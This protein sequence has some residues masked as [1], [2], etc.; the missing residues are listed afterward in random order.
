[1]K[2]QNGDRRFR[3]RGICSVGLVLAMLAST[4]VLGAPAQCVPGSCDDNDPCTDDTCDPNAGCIHTPTNCD[5]GSV[6]TVDSCSPGG[7]TG[8][9]TLLISHDISQ[10]ERQYQKNGTFVQTWGAI[11]QATG[12]AVD[13]SGVVYICN[14]NFGN[15]VIEKR[16]PGNVSLGTITA[17]V[18][19]QWIEDMGNF[20]SGYILAGTDAGNVFRIDTTTGAGVLLFSTGHSIIGV[21]YDGANIWTTG[22][23]SSTLVYKRDLS[24]SVL[25]SFNTGQL[26]SGIGYDPDD[27]TLW[28]GHAGGQ[29][30][31]H[32]QLGALLGGFATA[33]GGQLIDGLELGHLPFPEG[34]L[35][36]AFDCNDNDPCTDDPCDPV[37][38][39]SHPP[40][41]CNDGNL[42]TD[43]MCVPETGCVTTP[44]NAAC[45]DGNLCTTGDTCS[46]GFCQP[47]TPFVCDDGNACTTDSCDPRTGCAYVPNA[48]PCSDGNACTIEDACVEG[49]CHPG[50]PVACNDNNVCTTDSCIPAVGCVYSNNT[51]ACND[52]NAC[53]SGEVCVNGTCQLGVGVTC[54]PSDQC[55]AAGLCDPATGVC[56]NPA[57]PNGTPCNDGNPCTVG[58]VCIGGACGGV[59]VITTPAETQNLA[60]VNRSTYSWSAASDATA[61]DAVRGNVAALPVG[62]SAG[63]EVCFESLSGPEL[64]D[65][66]TP[67]PGAGFWYLSRA[68]NPCGPGPY[69]TQSNGTVRVTTSCP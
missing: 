29:V 65:T 48:N 34:C 67:A 46:G 56:S 1:M 40:H 63:G 15:N 35:H 17:T 3:F 21:T 19:G 16:G 11:G 69:G 43:D 60:A 57:K 25:A 2:L 6:C 44:N 26:N 54:S 58:E 41:I 38:G 13:G 49:A 37:A 36:T 4:Y 50:F 18:A 64:V 30:T 66:A 23:S 32:S 22:G 51:G 10:L 27:G 42:C 31:H 20:T 8:I 24:G 33:A 53:T 68:R 62:S 7:G 52:G 45:E 61:Y 14:P 28:I 5:D 12:A 59:T 9:A 55:H 39:C 47:G